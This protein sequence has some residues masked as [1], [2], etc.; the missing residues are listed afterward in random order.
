MLNVEKSIY[1]GSPHNPAAYCMLHHG[2]LT[3]RE[4]KHKDCLRKQ[5]HHLIKNDTHEYWK[6]RELQ[7]QRK[8]NVQ[9]G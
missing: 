4:L 9:K 7:K 3:V 5:C 6:Q 8:I 2:S 1:G